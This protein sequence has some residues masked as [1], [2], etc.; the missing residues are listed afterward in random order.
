MTEA[1]LDRL[2]HA[3]GFQLPSFYRKIMMDYPRLW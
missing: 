1:D 2:T 3:L